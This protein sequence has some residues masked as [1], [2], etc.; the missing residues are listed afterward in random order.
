MSPKESG[1]MRNGDRAIS[2]RSPVR[3]D[4][5]EP[6][7]ITLLLFAFLASAA[8]IAER[9][10]SSTCNVDVDVERYGNVERYCEYD[11]YMEWYCY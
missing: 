5:C 6:L 2:P 8:A 10:S 3:C 1:S 11:S 4:A 7:L 9:G